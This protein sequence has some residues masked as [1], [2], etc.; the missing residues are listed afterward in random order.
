[1]SYGSSLM[2]ENNNLIDFQKEKVPLNKKVY[3]KNQL[4]P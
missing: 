3:K 2:E 1:M 4:V